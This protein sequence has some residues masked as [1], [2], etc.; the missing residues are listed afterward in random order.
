MNLYIDIE[1]IPSQLDWVKKE[2]EDG[3]TAPGQYKKPESIAKWLEDNR[4]SAADDEWRK[5][6]L[7]GALGEIVCISWAFGDDGILEVHR[8]LGESE[9]DMLEEFFNLLGDDLDSRSMRGEVIRPIWTGHYISGFDLRFIWQRCVINR[10]NPSISIPYNAKP[11]GGEIF[12]TL[13]EWKGVKSTPGGSLD[14][15]CKAMGMDGK[16][17]IDGS[18]VWDYVKDGRIDEVVE[19]CKDDVKKVRDLHKRMMFIK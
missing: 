8:D 7:N 16:G 18:K 17:D 3:I 4:E 5:T 10:I 12:D 9:A 11:W 1:T 2:I 19:Y 13:I 6:G 14:A 15:V